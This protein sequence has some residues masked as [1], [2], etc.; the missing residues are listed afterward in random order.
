MRFRGTLVLLILAAALGGYLLLIEQPR[1]QEQQERKAAEEKLTQLSRSVIFHVTISRPDS[2]ILNFI[3]EGKKWRMLAPVS[4]LADPASLNMLV[5]SIVDAK[6]ARRL[7]PDS[8]ALAQFGLDKPA[9]VVTLATA[10]Q[11]TTLT[12]RLGVHNITK[13]HFYAQLD[14]SGQVLM[15]PAGIRRYALKEVPDYRN[16]KVIEFDL[17]EVKKLEITRGKNTMIWER[18]P[19]GEW[20]TVAGKD[21]IRGDRNAVEGVLRRLKALRVKEIAS[22]NPADF[23]RYT[24]GEEKFVTLWIGE[25]R[26]KK[27]I[28]FG[29]KEKDNCY[30]KRDS[31]NR[32]VLVPNSILEIFAKSLSDLRDRKLLHFERAQLARIEI[33]APDTAGTIVKT[34]TDWAYANPALGSIQQY[35]VG[36]FLYRLENLKFEEVEKEKFPSAEGYGFDKPSYRIA[37]YDQEDKPV[38]EL[39]CGNESSP[40]RYYA[41]SSSSRL[42]AVVSK[43]SLDQVLKSFRDIRKP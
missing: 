43:E 41:S 25:D 15:L 16:K 24:P 5:S 20:L 17:P 37:L 32:I 27:V 40:G 31:K 38:D 12:L 28:R 6:I 35:K 29:R 21:T 30:A 3:R 2:L 39:L 22:D 9:A 34:G 1:Y 4:D 7:E 18:D 42:L 33:T 23:R 14:T 26:A 13:S 11:D 36:S 10:D 8:A 19:G